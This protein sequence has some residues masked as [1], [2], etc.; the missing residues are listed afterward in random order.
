MVGYSAGSTGEPLWRDTGRDPMASR[1]GG[2]LGGIQDTRRDHLAGYSRD[3]LA[4]SSGEILGGIHSS[5]SGGIL[6]G[7]HWRAALAGNWVGAW[8]R[9]IA[10]ADS[11]IKSNNPFLSGGE[12]I[13]QGRAPF[14]SN[15]VY[16]HILTKSCLAIASTRSFLMKNNNKKR[17]KTQEQSMA[18]SK[19]TFL[20]KT[21]KSKTPRPGASRDAAP[22]ARCPEPALWRPAPAAAAPPPPPA[23]KT[24]RGRLAVGWG[25]GV[26][27]VSGIHA[28]VHVHIQMFMNIKLQLLLKSVSTKEGQKE[29]CAGMCILSIYIHI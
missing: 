5:S 21:K 12:Q 25:R 10:N 19:G 11:N 29:L 18:W 4:S 27:V 15:C 17:D 23:K 26:A 1:S 20:F 16:R 3:P 6:G 13:A 14:S 8:F 2:I 28:T 9:S 24:R 22:A 7:I